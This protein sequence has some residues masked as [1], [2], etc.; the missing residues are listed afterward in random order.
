[1]GVSFSI[2]NCY[3][4]KNLSWAEAQCSQTCKLGQAFSRPSQAPE[5]WPEE[6]LWPEVLVPLS[7]LTFLVTT[8]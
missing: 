5:Q 4:A 1:M 8:F 6:C 3:W 7:D 2:A